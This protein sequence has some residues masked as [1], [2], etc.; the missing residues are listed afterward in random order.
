VQISAVVTDRAGRPYLPATTLK[1]NLRRWLSRRVSR[2]ELLDALFGS[3]EETNAQ[4]GKLELEDAPLAAFHQP[5]LPPP[6]WCFERQTGV[7]TRVAINRLTRTARQEKLFHREYV[8]P[9]V[10]FQVTV[11][12]QDLDDLHQPPTTLS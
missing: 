7:E 9:G 1:G 6:Y 10:T 11:I 5:P 3:G 12:G 2:Q 8:P 4:G